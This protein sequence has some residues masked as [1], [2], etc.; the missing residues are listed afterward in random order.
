[1][2]AVATTAPTKHDLPTWTH[3]NLEVR[4]PLLILLT[5]MILQQLPTPHHNDGEGNDEAR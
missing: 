2:T 3:L 5:R 4:Q 1:M